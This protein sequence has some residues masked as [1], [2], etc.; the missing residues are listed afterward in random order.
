VCFKKHQNIEYYYK[1]EGYD[2][3]WHQTK[4]SYAVYKQ[5]DAG[6]YTFKIK[7]CEYGNCQEKIFPITISIEKPFWQRLWFINLCII[8]FLWLIMLAFYVQSIRNKRNKKLLEENIRLK[9]KELSVQQTDI[10][11]SILYTKLIQ[12][13]TLPRMKS[14][15]KENYFDS[16][17][18]QESEEKICS[19]FFWYHKTDEKLVLVLIDPQVK[20][21]PGGLISVWL[22]NSLESVVQV[23]RIFDPLLI[24]NHLQGQINQ[25]LNDLGEKP[26]FNASV[27]SIDFTK[28][29]LLY[30]AN[31]Q[32]I[33]FINQNNEALINIQ[34]K[35]N[36]TSDFVGREMENISV[37]LNSIQS[38]YT[39]T[40]GY[41]SYGISSKNFIS[42]LGEN[43][44]NDLYEEKEH[45][46]NLLDMEDLPSQEKDDFTLIGLRLIR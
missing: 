42:F 24:L 6:D 26:N 28:N 37:D 30:C 39:F 17:L 44:R 16:Y 3:D 11:N 21:V 7:M 34:D 19:D 25:N 1:L 9:N 10:N 5:L 22:M 13:A 35:S 43:Q 40:D 2:S 38:V 23:H 4:N 29:E 8:L 27:I 15:K 20:G 32:Y 46:L 31:N 14:L 36:S 45:I 12:R 33:V 18:I 41:Q